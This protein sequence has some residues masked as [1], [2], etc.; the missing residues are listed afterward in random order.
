MS[1]V[2]LCQCV[3][4]R[5]IRV[6]SISLNTITLLLAVHHSPVELSCTILTR[7]FAE[8]MERLQRCMVRLAGLPLTSYTTQHYLAYLNYHYTI[9]VLHLI[10]AGGFPD[11]MMSFL[12]RSRTESPA[13]GVLKLAYFPQNCHRFPHRLDSWSTLDGNNMSA[14]WKDSYF[15]GQCPQRM[16]HRAV[17][18]QLV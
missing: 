3:T 2:C 12:P 1:F 5:R 10:I 14:T 8:R 9:P 17:S 18:F 16:P 15:P 7:A 11:G 6:H 4:Y 13:H